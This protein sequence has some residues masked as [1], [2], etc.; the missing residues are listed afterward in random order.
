[1]EKIK[2]NYPSV[3]VFAEG[4]KSTPEKSLPFNEVLDRIKN[5]ANKLKIDKCRKFVAQGNMVE[6]D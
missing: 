6:Y 2:R 4:S 1:M 5:G 3:S